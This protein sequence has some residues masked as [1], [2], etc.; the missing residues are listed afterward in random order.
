MF[1]HGLE[2]RSSQP[3]SSAR[4]IIARKISN[5]RLAAPGL[6]WLAASKHSPTSLGF[7][8]VEAYPPE[9]G[10]NPGLEIDP[11]GL[12]PRRPP[13]R[14]ATE[15]VFL[16]KYLERGHPRRYMRFLGGV[17]P[18]SAAGEKIPGT[19][20]RGTEVHLPVLA[21]D[22]APDPALNAGLDDVHLAA[23]GVD[24]QPELGHGPVEQDRF[25]LAR[26]TTEG[27]T[28][29]EINGRH[30]FPPYWFV[31]LYRRG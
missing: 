25:L 27:E 19:A 13:A 28:G 2:S 20:A 7:D 1:R 30:G 26:L 11:Y 18:G 17:L 5:A 29:G 22:H 6:S 31:R 4:D 23:R 3:H 14:I 12:S 8:L 21:D 24:V 16:S 10:Q 15:H 9:R